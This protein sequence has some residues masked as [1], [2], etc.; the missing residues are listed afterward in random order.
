MQDPGS[1]VLAPGSWIIAFYLLTLFGQ[2]F[3]NSMNS[4]EIVRSSV[5]SS[6]IAQ[7]R[8]FANRMGASKSQL[9]TWACDLVKMGVRPPLAPFIIHT[10]R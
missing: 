5:K 7:N 3:R 9:P 1:W 8:W 2:Y 4:S 6:E 10:G